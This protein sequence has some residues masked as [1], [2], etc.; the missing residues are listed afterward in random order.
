MPLLFENSCVSATRRSSGAI[1]VPWSHTRSGRVRTFL[2]LIAMAVGV[3]I[4]FAHFRAADVARLNAALG[5][6]FEKKPHVLD[7]V[8]V[9]KIS[10]D[11]PPEVHDFGRGP[12]VYEKQPAAV[13]ACSEVASKRHRPGRWHV[14]VR[15]LRPKAGRSERVRAGRSACLRRASAPRRLPGLLVRADGG[16]LL[17]ARRR[18]THARALVS[19]AGTRSAGYHGIRAPCHSK[20]SRP[21]SLR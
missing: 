10:V 18:R 20:H 11:G 1:H 14:S 21:A 2:G 16:R 17:H 4:C 12:G 13:P 3:A 19:L 15:A 5:V 7:S 8:D 9:M 6:L